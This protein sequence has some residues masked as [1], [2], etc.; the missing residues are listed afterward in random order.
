LER[1][2]IRKFIEPARRVAEAEYDLIRLRQARHELFAKYSPAGRFDKGTIGLTVKLSALI[3]QLMLIDR[4]ERRALSRRK[5]AIRKLDAATL[6]GT[7]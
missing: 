6:Q 4:Y 3:K 7:K 2:L 5:F 1:E